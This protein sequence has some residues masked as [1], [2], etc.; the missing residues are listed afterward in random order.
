ML[1]PSTKKRVQSSAPQPTNLRPCWNGK[2]AAWSQKLCDRLCRDLIHSPYY[3]TH[4]FRQRSDLQISLQSSK[5][6]ES[7]DENPRQAQSISKSP[8]TAAIETVDAL[9]EI[10]YNAVSIQRFAYW[11][12]HDGFG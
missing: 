12:H 1:T 4:G 7:P 5:E 6:E 11:S 3:K 8:S 10:C 9:V 2:V